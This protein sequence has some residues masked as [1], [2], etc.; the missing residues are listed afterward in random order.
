M[1]GVKISTLLPPPE[2]VS[3]GVGEFEVSGL[4][5]PQITKLIAQHRMEFARLLVLGS[6]DEP[7]Y[8]EIVDLAPGMVVEVIA[9]AAG[10]EKEPEEIEAIGKLPAGVH[11]IALE[12]IWRLTVVDPKNFK[13]LLQKVT[14]SL[15]ELGSVK[16]AGSLERTSVV[17]LQ[18]K[19]T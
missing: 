13:A 4:T 5:L 18:P 2:K 11:L 14:G 16:L 6:N 9:M 19:G 7:N 17:S 10:C 15:R 1:N 12:K 8:S 3:T